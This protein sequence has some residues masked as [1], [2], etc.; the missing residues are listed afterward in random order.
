MRETQEAR[1][2]QPN[3]IVQISLPFD[4]SLSVRLPIIV[5]KQF[6]DPSVKQSAGPS[7]A[8]RLPAEVAEHPD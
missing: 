3:K 5:I 6:P 2:D 1:R 4:C 7:P 8:A